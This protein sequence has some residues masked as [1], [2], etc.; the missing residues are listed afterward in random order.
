MR[1][2]AEKFAEL[3][4]KGSKALVAYL[5]AGYP[6]LETTRDL[7]LALRAGVDVLELGIFRIP[8]PITPPS[9]KPR[10]LFRERTTLFGPPPSPDLRI[11]RD[12]YVLFSYYNPFVFGNHRFAQ[13][14]SGGADRVLV[15]DLRWRAA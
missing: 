10:R 4:K 14:H 13:S 5:T 15:V 6:D 12:P 1:R 8:P 3:K 11:D 2:I 7:V 9:K